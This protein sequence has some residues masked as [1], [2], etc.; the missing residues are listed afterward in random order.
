MLQV[1][2]PQFRRGRL[3]TEH[4]VPRQQQYFVDANGQILV[5]AGSGHHRSASVSGQ[6]PAQ[7]FIDNRN[8]FEE[9]TGRPRSAHGNHVFIDDDGVYWE[10]ARSRSRARGRDKSPPKTDLDEKTKGKLKDYEDMV[11]KQKRKDEQKR[12]EEQIRVDRLKEEAERK[13][14]EEE[15]KKLKDAAI[16]EYEAKKEADRIKKE[17]E[18]E[19]ED[20]EFKERMRRTLRANGYSDEQIER[21]M[22]KAE[23]KGTSSGESDTRVL[24]LNRPTYIKVHRKHLDTETLNTYQLPWE[25]D[26]VS[27]MRSGTKDLMY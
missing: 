19:K 1:Q 17:K 26:D 10:R 6:Q 27:R 5:P 20:D 2:R 24:A 16:K 9:P 11:E 3:N 8:A 7:I 4:A 13:K 14:R 12:I 25:W 15:E 23:K 21:M 18:K 22:K